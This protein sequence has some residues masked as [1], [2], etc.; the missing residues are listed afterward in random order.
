MA[1]L[2]AQVSPEKEFRQGW[3]VF[4]GGL[5]LDRPNETEDNELQ[6]AENFILNKRGI[7]I[8]RPGSVKLNTGTLNLNEYFTHMVDYNRRSGASYTSHFIGFTNQG[9]MMRLESDGTYTQIA[10]GYA[11]NIL[12]RS[13]IWQNTLIFSTDLTTRLQSYDATTVQ[14]LSA[15]APFAKDLKYF[16][17][18]LWAIDDLTLY[19]SKDN[20]PT[21]WTPTPSTPDALQF[22]VAPDTGGRAMTLHRFFDSLLVGKQH[23]MVELIGQSIADFRVGDKSIDAGVSFPGGMISVGNNVWVMDDT[24]VRSLA[25]VQQYGD[26]N[27][28]IINNKVHPFFEGSLKF[29]GLEKAFAEQMAMHH[30]HDRNLV[31][32]AFTGKGDTTN[33]QVIFADHTWD[34]NN[35]AWMIQKYPFPISCFAKRQSAT[36]GEECYA[37]DYSGNIY[38]MLVPTATKDHVTSYVKRFLSGSKFFG[39]PRKYK[40]FMNVYFTFLSSTPG[41]VTVRLKGL[42]NEMFQQM[43]VGGLSGSKW[44]SM[45][46]GVDT[47]GGTDSN[48]RVVLNDLNFRD[49]KLALGVSSSLDGHASFG[50]M[51]VDG[52]AK[53]YRRIGV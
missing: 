51:I 14:N 13:E 49:I 17:G 11:A 1:R 10:T 26:I 8:T 33:S 24:F 23:F 43:T 30:F 44:G 32:I 35:P 29:K 28:S 48:E 12:F 53:S 7:L 31:L 21:G 39:D 4:N 6:E 52:T 34:P 38:R 37:A 27:Q 45:V 18:K 19:G 15:D 20:D 2:A 40:R 36:L 16:N 41:D 47:W 25:G 3:I 22:F 42:E 46:W 9:R 5:N 50:E